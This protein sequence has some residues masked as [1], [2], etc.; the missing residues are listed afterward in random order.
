MCCVPTRMQRTRLSTFSRCVM[1]HSLTIPFSPR[2]QRDWP[3]LA[4][5]QCA[6]WSAPSCRRGPSC[7]THVQYSQSAV[8]MVSFYWMDSRGPRVLFQLTCR[9]VSVR[10]LRS[11]KSDSESS[12]VG[13]PLQPVVNGSCWAPLVSCCHII[14]RN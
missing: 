8:P 12:D 7:G 6:F 10:L 9:P 14:L 4:H 3:C 13:S 11:S 5:S 1:L 2:T